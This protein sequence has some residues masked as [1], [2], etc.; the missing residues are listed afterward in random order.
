MRFKKAKAALAAALV[1]GACVMGVGCQRNKTYDYKTITVYDVLDENRPYQ[2]TYREYNYLIQHVGESEEDQQMICHR[3]EKW[4]LS[5]D[6]SFVNV[7]T[8][9]GRNFKIALKKVTGEDTKLGAREYIEMAPDNV[10]IV[11]IEEKGF[12]YKGFLNSKCVDEQWEQE[13]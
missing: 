5:P 7:Q 13:K 12:Q 4:G 11:C 8:E 10:T 1:A 2:F 3:V 6:L 9:C